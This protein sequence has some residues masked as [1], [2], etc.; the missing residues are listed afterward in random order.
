MDNEDGTCIISDWTQTNDIIMENENQWKEYRQALRDLP[1]I[2]ENP[3]NPTWPEPPQVK[4]SCG[5]TTLTQ[6]KTLH[7]QFEDATYVDPI[8]NPN[9]KQ[10]KPNLGTP[11]PNLGTPK[12]NLGTPKPNWKPLAPSLSTLSRLKRSRR[13]TSSP[14]SLSLRQR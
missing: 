3:E 12:P 4:I 2:T 8:K 11:K 9:W 1:S 10:P 5:S 6:L 13:K 7:T 14:A